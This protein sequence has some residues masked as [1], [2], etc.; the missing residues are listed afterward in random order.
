MNHLYLTI[1]SLFICLLLSPQLQASAVCDCLI[2]KE[3][4]EIAYSDGCDKPEDI[5]S[6]VLEDSLGSIDLFQFIDLRD[7]EVVIGDDTQ[8]RFLASTL[9]SSGTKFTL[10]GSSAEL[11]MVADGHVTSSVSG[12]AGAHFL[13]G[14]VLGLDALVCLSLRV[15][16]FNVTNPPPSPCTLGSS[17]NLPVDL[18]EWTAEPVN[19][20][21]DLTWQTAMETENDFYRLL[22]STDGR[23]YQELARLTGQGDFS[24]YQ[25]LHNRPAA[26]LNLYRLDQ[27]DFDGTVNS[28]G[29]RSAEWAGSVDLSTVV[30]PNPAAAGSLINLELPTAYLHNESPSA[31]LLDQSGRTIGSYPISSN[32]TLQLPQDLAA[33][34]YVL[35]VQHQAVKIIVH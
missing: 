25:Y 22:H 21:I 3:H 33:G 13:N 30:S 14:I 29:L 9:V 18:I 17:G 8:A 20:G 15:D 11:E 31:D 7:I 4:D 12:P 10:D 28:L 1:T 26:G 34:L 5:C 16:L 6:L 19:T 35:R 32:N 23:F 24:D 2:T 27:H